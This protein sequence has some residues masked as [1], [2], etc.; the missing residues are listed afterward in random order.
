MNMTDHSIH[1]RTHTVKD[2]SHYGVIVTENIGSL[3]DATETGAA[4]SGNRRLCGEGI[5]R[6]HFAGYSSN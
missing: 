3:A 5:P 4:I 2:K 6:E 1:L